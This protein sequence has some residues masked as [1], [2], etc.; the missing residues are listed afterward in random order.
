[1]RTTLAID[2]HV[3]KKF[4]ERMAEKKLPLKRVVN[5]KLRASLSD[6]NRKHKASLLG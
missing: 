4:R 1:M 2:P 6:K 3:A 5:D